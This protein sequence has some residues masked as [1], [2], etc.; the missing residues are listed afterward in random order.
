[1]EIKDA[2]EEIQPLLMNFLKGVQY[3]VK[4]ITPTLELI[5]LGVFIVRPGVSLTFDRIRY[6]IISLT[7]RNYWTQLMSH[8]KP[9]VS[10][11]QVENSSSTQVVS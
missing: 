3:Q 10:V 7:N 5:L 11:L 9:S 4:M 2:K 8:H 1:M 6:K